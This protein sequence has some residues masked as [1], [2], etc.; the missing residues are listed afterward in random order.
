M[1]RRVYANGGAK[2][3][4]GRPVGAI[5]KRT[6]ETVALARKT[7]KLPHEIMLQIAQAT[8]GAKVKGWGTVDK[9]DKKWACYSCANYFAPKMTATD[10]SGNVYIMALP[11]EALNRLSVRELELAEKL[12]GKLASNGSNGHAPML[13][14]APID[15]DPD[16]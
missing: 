11:Q 6:R 1:E 7:G 12:F 8:I 5:N 15:Y 10:H 3:R 14:P 4:G 2:N 9:E 16:D 13:L